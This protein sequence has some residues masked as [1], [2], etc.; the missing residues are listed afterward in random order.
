MSLC[1]VTEP[2]TRKENCFDK[3]GVFIFFKFINS[4]IWEALQTI[5]GAITGKK[6]L[7]SIIPGFL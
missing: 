3:F 6:D 1:N 7:C 5:R 2:L 4:Y